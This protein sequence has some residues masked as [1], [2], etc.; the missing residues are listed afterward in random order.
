RIC[1]VPSPP[2]GARMP[3][4]PIS[5]RSALRILAGTAAGLAGAPAVLRGRFRLFADSPAEYSARTVRLVREST[6]VDLLC[7]FAFPDL[8]GEGTPLATRW[9]REPETFT[10]QHFALFRDSGVD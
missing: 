2:P 5:R 4:P 1:P 6:V 10:E 7:Q 3:P 9:L 8:R